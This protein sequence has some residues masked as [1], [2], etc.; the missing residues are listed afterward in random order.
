MI[1]LSASSAAARSRSRTRV[2]RRPPSLDP[3]ASHRRAPL[4]PSS[5][6]SSSGARSSGGKQH[7]H[8]LGCR[9]LSRLLAT[10]SRFATVAA[11]AAVM[12]SIHGLPGGSSAPQVSHSGDAMLRW[13][14][15]QRFQAGWQPA[16]S[17]VSLVDAMDRSWLICQKY[18]STELDRRK[19]CDRR[20]LIAGWGSTQDDGPLTSA[21][22]A[23][24]IGADDGRH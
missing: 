12:Q 8:P 14:C 4:A 24:H 9:W 7:R 23:R 5:P 10:A 18:V 21:G 6:S 1:S 15:R 17:G 16:S 20:I 2:G 11:A 3:P 19:S 22:E 13:R